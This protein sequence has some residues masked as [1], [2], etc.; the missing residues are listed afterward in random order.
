MYEHYAT[1][2]DRQRD[3]TD[4]CS[5]DAAAGTVSI[6]ES[7]AD[8]LETL[9]IVFELSPAHPAY[10]R[11]VLADLDTSPQELT[12]GEETTIIASDIPDIL[13][14]AGGI[15]PFAAAFPGRPRSTTRSTPICASKPSMSTCPANRRPTGSPAIW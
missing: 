10:E 14:E 5:L 6:P 4:E 2:G 3:I 15:A 12:V 1:F 9:G 7:Y 8:T 13:A 11:F